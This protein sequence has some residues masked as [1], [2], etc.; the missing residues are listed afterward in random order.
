MELNTLRAFYDSIENRNEIKN[1]LF[2]NLD[3]KKEEII[4]LNIVQVEYKFKEK[5]VTIAYY[6]EDKEYP[7]K[8]LSFEEFGNL[9]QNKAGIYNLTNAILLCAIIDTGSINGTELKNI[10]SYTDNYLKNPIIEFEE[11]NNAIKYLL[12]LGL[13]EE[14]NKKFFVNKEW[15]NRK[16]KNRPKTYK[17]RM[18]ENIQKQLYLAEKS[19]ELKKNI[20]TTMS[21][22]YFESIIK[23]Y[24]MKI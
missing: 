24:I 19:H 2:E 5:Y 3:S 6:C 14:F 8:K 15:Y 16:F 10:I 13:V 18:V 11:F 7:D 12:Q 1:V 23:E 20:K 21:E 22:N 9:L 17:Y 4:V